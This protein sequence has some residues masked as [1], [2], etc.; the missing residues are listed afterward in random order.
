LENDLQK[1]C[2]RQASPH[3]VMHSHLAVFEQLLFQAQAHFKFVSGSVKFYSDTRILHFPMPDKPHRSK[4]RV[5]AKRAREPKKP[6]KY[7]VPGNNIRNDDS[8]S[9]V[10]CQCGL[11]ASSFVSKKEA[12][13]GR[14][15]LVCSKKVLKCKFFEWVNE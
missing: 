1:I 12:T 2:S 3:S 7:N 4:P 5:E 13:F 9:E 14:K 8:N 15:F 11:I 6:S 10:R